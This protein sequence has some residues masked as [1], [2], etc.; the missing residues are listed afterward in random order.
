[1]LWVQVH[2]R[3]GRRQ[4][5]ADLNE[6]VEHDGVVDAAGDSRA[7]ARRELRQELRSQRIKMH[8]ERQGAAGHR[9][10]SFSTFANGDPRACA[11]GAAVPTPTPPIAGRL[12]RPTP[13]HRAEWRAGVAARKR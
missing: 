11:A 3:V 2:V 7:D 9:S 12:E 10:R 4:E 13:G 5:G 1:M 8:T 6:S